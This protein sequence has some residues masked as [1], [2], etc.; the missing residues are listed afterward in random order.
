MSR[1]IN[2]YTDFGFKRLFGTEGN[3]DLLIDFLNC[4]MPLK[5][6][7]NSLTF[8]NVEQQGE[9]IADRKAIYDIHCKGV[10]GDTFIIEMQ[11]AKLNFFK[12][13]ALFY[14]SL[15]IRDQAPKGS[16]W[17]FGLLPIYYIAILDFPYDEHEEIRK[18]DRN[19]QLR[20]EDGFVFYDKL[21]FRFLQMPFFNKTEEELESHYDKWC[22]FLKH[23]ESFDEI[24]KI[25]NEKIFEKAFLSAELAAM[26]EQERK[27]YETSRFSYL[28]TKA[29]FDTATEKGRQEGRQEG[30]MEEKY[31]IA[32]KMKE[33]GL[34]EITI[35]K[36]TNL[37]ISEI[38]KI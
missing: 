11:K 7:I 25:L 38:R 20:D 1:Y 33:A 19:V 28:T 35:S 5:H 37:D 34:N 30:A 29:A 27:V 9:I 3:K 36:F 15:P 6:K 14:V 23:L 26:S 18:F 4:L 2:P 13:R 32:K 24:P 22:Y 21:G 12:D 8:S 16:D 10:N 17:D 31:N